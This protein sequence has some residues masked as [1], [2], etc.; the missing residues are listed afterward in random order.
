MVSQQ[1]DGTSCG[2][3]AVAT[4][5]SIFLKL[6]TQAQR[7]KHKKLRISLLSFMEAAELKAFPFKTDLHSAA[8]NVMLPDWQR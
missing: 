1:P 3:Y 5:T 4:L 7:Y 8:L 6:D 2:F